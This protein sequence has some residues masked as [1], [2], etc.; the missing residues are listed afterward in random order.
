MLIVLL[1]V[2]LSSRNDYCRSHLNEVPVAQVVTLVYFLPF[3]FRRS[4][5]VVFDIAY[6]VFRN[7]NV[8]SSGYESF[9]K[10]EGNWEGKKS[11]K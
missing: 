8:S 7:L 3:I 5:N 6:S 1:Y 10:N 9:Y 4:F 2:L 11:K